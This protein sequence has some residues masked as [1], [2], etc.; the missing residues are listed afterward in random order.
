MEEVTAKAEAAPTQEPEKV[1]PTLEELTAMVEKQQATIE[2]LSSSKERILEES[3]DYKTKF[4]SLRTE[5]EGAE[6]LKL[7]DSENWKELLD[8]EKNKNFDAQEEMKTLKQRTVRSNINLAVSRLAPDA[9]DTEDLMKL[10]EFGDMQIN[11]DLSV[12]GLDN[13]V[14]GIRESKP[15][16]FKDQTAPGQVSSRPGSGAPA[17]VDWKT[18]SIDEKAQ[19]AMDAMVSESK[20]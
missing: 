17:K 2:S 19:L 12:S 1:T 8:I 15:W 20:L 18:L 4:N 16:M 14:K 11:E 3:K 6:R 5:V 7:E 10:L 13:L 9:H